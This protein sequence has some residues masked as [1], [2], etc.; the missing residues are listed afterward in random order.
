MIY[1]DYSL[2]IMD[3]IFFSTKYML[4]EHL[5]GFYVSTYKTKSGEERKL[6]TSHFEPT[7]ARKAFPC[8][9][10]PD[11]KAK[12]LMTLIHDADKEAFFN[13]PKKQGQLV[14]N[15]PEH[16]RDEFEETVNMSTYLVAFV[17]CDFEVISAVTTKGINVSVIASTD[18]ISQVTFRPFFYLLKP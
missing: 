5:E 13:T 18:K 4:S 11:L 3:M 2:S 6:A 17:V 12:F 1:L 7:Y 16:V 15:K 9:D 10:E 8:F 14:H